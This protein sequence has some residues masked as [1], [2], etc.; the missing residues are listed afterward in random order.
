MKLNTWLAAGLVLATLASPLTWAGERHRHH[1]HG[2][3]HQPVVHE[4]HHYYHH[5][6]PDHRERGPRHTWA[7]VTDVI[8]IT[9][10]VPRH[11]PRQTCWDEPVRY[12]ADYP[13]ATGTIVGGIIGGA[14]GNAV[15][16]KKV[17]K[18]IGTAVGAVL[19]A[20]IGH[21]L[22]VGRGG[23]GG[24]RNETRCETYDD[25]RYDES[26]VGYR[27]F[28]RHA[29]RTYETRTD[30]HPGDRIRIPLD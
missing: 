7:P 11:T 24:Y 20:S 16:H 1:H 29:G 6:G 28:Y 12:E 3:R 15:G 17:N 25:V 18:R 21:D 2:H 19:G 13:S 27:V 30:H 10:S 23:G 4:H 22:S 26:V 9:R 14:I 5:R 8:P